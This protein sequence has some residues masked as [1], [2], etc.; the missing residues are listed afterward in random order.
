M[1]QQGQPVSIS[2]IDICPCELQ[3]LLGCRCTATSKEVLSRLHAH[4]WRSGDREPSRGTPYHRGRIAMGIAS[5][6][7][8]RSPHPSCILRRGLQQVLESIDVI[9]VER[10]PQVSA[11]NLCHSFCNLG[12]KGSIDLL[13]VKVFEQAGQRNELSGSCT[14]HYLHH[15]TA[16]SSPNPS[17]PNQAQSAEPSTLSA[18]NLKSSRYRSYDFFWGLSVP[19]PLRTACQSR[20]TLGCRGSLSGEP[21]DVSKAN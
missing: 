17:D 3:A 15:Q 6:T 20:C 12:A 4:Q 19:E 21:V 13:F 9:F 14:S 5:T 1:M 8:T 18:Q 11:V 7:A 2:P 10:L 16:V